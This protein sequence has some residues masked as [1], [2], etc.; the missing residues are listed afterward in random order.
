MGRVADTVQSIMPGVD[1]VL[2]AVREQARRETCPEKASGVCGRGCEYPECK[3][4][5]R[6]LS[7]YYDH[8]QG[9]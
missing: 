5:L 2:R 7:E 8:M 3:D 1:E 6:A 9:R 4:R